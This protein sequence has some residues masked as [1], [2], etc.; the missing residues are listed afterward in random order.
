M[1][2][3]EYGIE[4]FHKSLLSNLALFSRETAIEVSSKSGSYVAK[5][6]RKS[7]QS[8]THHFVK[9]SAHRVAF[10]ESRTQRL[11]DM[12]REDGDKVAPGSLA[13]FIGW[14]SYERN[15]LRPTVVVAEAFQTHRA[16][17][18]V[19]GKVVGSKL[20]KGTGVRTMALIERIDKGHFSADYNEFFGFN[21]DVK[22]PK[23][24]NFKAEGYRNALPK[25]NE[26]LTKEWSR[27]MDVAMQRTELQSQ[28]VAGGR[29]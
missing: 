12:E 23:A 3:L 28:R 24:Y 29:S 9:V 27:I 13:N 20:V 26:T 16:K 6:I 4:S 17:I 18:R 21:D 2:G 22:D 7:M 5:E 1:I 14:Q 15:Y 8:K 10:D 19:N 25:V 11:G